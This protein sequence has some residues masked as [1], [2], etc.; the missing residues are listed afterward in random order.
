MKLKI[1]KIKQLMPLILRFDMKSDNKVFDEP[2]DTIIELTTG[3]KLCYCIKKGAVT[4]L[5]SVPKL[6]RSF[7]DND[8]PGIV[9]AAIIHDI[10]FATHFLNFRDSNCLFRQMCVM[11]GLG[12]FRSWLAWLAVSSFVG[13]NRYKSYPGK[14]NGLGLYKAEDVM[15]WFG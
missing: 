14:A 15:C 1:K 11:G 10:N 2:F 8:D 4:D 13:H 6:L 7:V 12:K 5:A 9:L 3:V